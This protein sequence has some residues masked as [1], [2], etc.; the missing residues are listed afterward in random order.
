MIDRRWAHSFLK[1][2]T[3]YPSPIDIF[4]TKRKAVIIFLQRPHTSRNCFTTNVLCLVSI[5]I[6]ASSCI[7]NLCLPNYQC[8]HKP[9]LRSQRFLPNERLFFRVPKPR[10][11]VRGGK[12]SV[13]QNK[14]MCVGDIPLRSKRPYFVAAGLSSS[15]SSFTFY[16]EYETIRR[17]HNAKS[18]S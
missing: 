14:T 18:Q 7:N 15:S 2:E 4:H 6:W 16:L 17:F 8:Q 1:S 5:R 9:S 12:M 10:N 11:S 3:R 13:F